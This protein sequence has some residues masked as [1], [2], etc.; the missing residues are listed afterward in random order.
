[1]GATDAN[2]MLEVAKEECIRLERENAELRTVINSV[3]FRRRYLMGMDEGQVVAELLEWKAN[4][5][6][7][8]REDKRHMGELA[9]V[10]E[11]VRAYN[12]SGLIPE[13]RLAAILAKTRSDA[14]DRVKREAAAEAVDDAKQLVM[15]YLAT[16]EQW[17]YDEVAE[18]LARRAAAIRAAPDPNHVTLGAWLSNF[19]KEDDRG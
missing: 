12:H 7:T 19:T 13:P 4:A 14:L 11:E 8:L 6:I 5:G 15:Q 9:A 16:A 3:D 18:A 10:I 1:M 2:E 17:R